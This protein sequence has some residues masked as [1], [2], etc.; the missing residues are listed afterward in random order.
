MKQS[1]KKNIAFLL[2]KYKSWLY[3]ILFFSSPVFAGTIT[4]TTGYTADT[5]ATNLFTGQD[6]S[7][8]VSLR[9]A[10]EAA[11]NLG[12]TTTIV[13]PAGTY[14][15]SLG[16]I[17]FGNKSENITING[18]DSSATI[19][20]MTS[21][22]QDRIFLINQSGTIANVITT[23]QNLKFTNGLLKSD[24][25]GGGAILAGG[26][27]NSLTITTCEFKG[28]A[29][30]SGST[31]GA[32]N[33]SGGGTIA[34]THSSFLSNANAT[35]DGG[36][37]YYFLQNNVSGSFNVTNCT[38]N[39]DSLTTTTAATGSAIQVATQGTNSG[40]FSS[41]INNNT[42]TNN[43][44]NGTLDAGA[45]MSVD[46]GYGGTV[47]LN[48]NRIYQNISTTTPNEYII[49]N[50]AGDGD[51]TNNW[52]GA[53]AGPST[54]QVGGTGTV[55]KSNWI[56]FEISGPDICS[57]APADTSLVTAS[58]LQNS[59]ATI[60]TAAN[61]SA[62]TGVPISFQ[63]VLGGT[64]FNAQTAIQTSGTATADFV[65]SAAGSGSLNAI[66]DAQTVSP[67]IA[68]T[69]TTLPTGHISIT[70]NT[71]TNNNTYISTCE[72]L[73][74]AVPSG[75]SPMSGSVTAEVWVESSVP[76][77]AGEPFVARHY[78]ITPA[79]ASTTSTGTITLYFTQA[80]FDAFNN[81]PGAA[82]HLPTGPNDANGIANLRIGKY[83]GISNDNSGLPASYTTGTPIVIDPIDANIVWDLV[84]NWWAVTFDVP[85]FS[86][87]IVQTSPV[88]LPVKLTSFTATAS[89][90]DGA[91]LYWNVAVQNGIKTYIVEKSTDGSSFV[92]TGAVAAN[93]LSDF[94]YSYTDSNLPTGT[95]YYRLEIVDEDGTISYSPIAIVDITTN[96]SQ[97]ILIYPNPVTDAF[98]IKQPN[99]IIANDA[100]LSDVN[101]KI[102]QTITLT[103]PQQT[104]NVKGYA[105][106][107]Y[108]L[109]FSNGSVYKINK[110]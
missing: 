27:S 51:A 2:A 45:V 20:N 91:I 77:Y 7:G 53:N 21:V 94:N 89:N 43:T 19:I 99:G 47:P 16:E 103:S 29:I 25:Y 13:V 73:N 33:I 4:V 30:S 52:W 110:Q 84:N 95:N 102:L 104:V 109:H 68:V 100:Q 65:A 55:D 98:T 15:L 58:F 37:V 70:Q 49:A 79:I 74:K 39:D 105:D 78:Q 9:G 83:P 86:G 88:V 69:S 24:G 96:Q 8:S 62:L 22:N 80:D 106:G 40:T 26:P 101:G 59:N 60:L 42:F 61:V 71:G 63:N 10:I 38:F 92:E 50:A 66:V 12:G 56:L 32:V 107:I 46:N 14:N 93:D 72:L 34:I 87:F 57:T 108:M 97:S 64:L 35:G 6:G 23:I 31:G 48:Y 54:A 18:A 67:N 1:T 28:N 17:I 85:S 82:L 41:S 5:H 75:A 90:S 11:D 81:D 36:A 44:S 3:I 76:S